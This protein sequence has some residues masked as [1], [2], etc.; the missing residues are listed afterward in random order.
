MATTKASSKSSYIKYGIWGII[1][2]L[3]IVCFFS[4][5]S[6]YNGLV[7]AEET[8]NESW[9][10]VQVQY[11]RRMDLI[12][13][14]VETVK[15]YA[16]HESTTFQ[17]VT[18]ARAGLVKAQEDVQASTPENP[19]EVP[20]NEAD[21]QRY[22]KAQSDLQKALNIYVNAVREAYPDLKADKQFQDLI[23]ILEGTENRIAMARTEYTKQV[24][25]F[26]IKVKRFPGNIWAGLFGFDA[27]PQY[28]AEEEAQKRPEFSF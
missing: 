22:T 25:E 28:A 8:V 27:K 13:S 21:F 6:S 11:Q 5:C 26:N 18:D 15:G 17:N 16:K 12:P 24:K 4:G 14:T 2:I 19:N 10:A 20:A 23:V 9:A 7:T 1:G 3:I